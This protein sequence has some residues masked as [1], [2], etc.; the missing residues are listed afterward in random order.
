MDLSLILPK[1]DGLFISNGPGDP[2]LCSALI[3]RFVVNL[4]NNL[5]ILSSRILI[6]HKFGLEIRINFKVR[7]GPIQQVLKI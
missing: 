4:T 6:S 5:E 7:R 2:A 3:T 1:F